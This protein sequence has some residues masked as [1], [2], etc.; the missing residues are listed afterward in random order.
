M[1]VAELL[2]ENSDETPLI[3]ADLR[4]HVLTDCEL[5][6]N[7]QLFPVS[8]VW[9]MGFGWSSSIVQS[10]MVNTLQSAGYDRQQLLTEE[11]CLP[12]PITPSLSVATDDVL[13][14]QRACP[15]EAQE[16]RPPLA[17]LEA[18]WERR[19]LSV[20]HSKPFDMQRGEVCLGVELVSGTSHMPKASRL[21]EILF[22][23]K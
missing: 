5:D 7:T 4:R 9:P 22:A 1:T 17:Q 19:G 6:A 13:H 16:M 23:L 20:Q 2:A 8:R 21:W 18:E 3:L 11:G 15:S 14:F 12:D 10:F